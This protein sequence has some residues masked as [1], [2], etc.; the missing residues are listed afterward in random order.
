[1]GSA[2]YKKIKGVTLAQFSVIG[3]RIPRIE[4]Q[5]VVT[6]EAKY[7]LDI[8]LPLKIDCL[9]YRIPYGN[10]SFYPC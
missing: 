4:G 6:G 10:R 9:L 8:V 3:Q 1:M 2:C 7:T 5:G